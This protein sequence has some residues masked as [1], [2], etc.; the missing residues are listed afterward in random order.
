MPLTAPPDH[1]KTWTVAAIGLSIVLFTLV[2]SRS[3]LPQVGDNIHSLPHGGYYKD[4]T[5][6]IFYGAPHKL[7]SLEKA[8]SVKFQPWA[9]VIGLIAVIVLINLLEHRGRCAC[10]RIH[11]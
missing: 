11:A 9:V 4:G 5:K 1:T 3:T 10:G 6:Q 7:N 2:Y 8:L